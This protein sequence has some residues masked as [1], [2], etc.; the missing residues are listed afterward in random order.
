MTQE[1]RIDDC[2]TRV[3]GASQTSTVAAL[4]LSAKIGVQPTVEVVARDY[5]PFDEETGVEIP[6]SG[7]LTAAQLA[8]LVTTGTATTT[9]I[10]ARA[11]K[12]QSAALR[13]VRLA[14]NRTAYATQS[15]PA[16]LNTTAYVTT[17]T[18]Y[19]AVANG[20]TKN[21]CVVGDS[22]AFRWTEAGTG[23]PVWEQC[24]AVFP[25]LTNMGINSDNTQGL[26]WRIANDSFP[27]QWSNLKVVMIQ[28]GTNNTTSAGLAAP[29]SD[30]IIRA[31][32][33][34]KANIPG[35]RIY[36]HGLMPRSDAT[37]DG[38]S[39]EVND[40][41]A[42]RH[43]EIEGCAYRDFRPEF[44]SSST[45]GAIITS[46]YEGDGLHLSTAGYTLLANLCRPTVEQL[47]RL[48]G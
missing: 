24:L 34:I 14:E 18:S 35:V 19:V 7:M 38:R 48:A 23:L 1:V 33:N 11:R 37:R 40:I 26:L 29:I 8:A 5:Q 46:L 28:V 21:I 13:M 9:S 42:V 36:L 25:D 30:A 3:T 31:C 15:E 6:S 10:W 43:R 12:G 41:L 27:R 22:I 39:K 47:L 16:P 20:N 4:Q 45:N 2:W 44:T 32:K 17:H